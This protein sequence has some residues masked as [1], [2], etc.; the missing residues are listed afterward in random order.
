MNFFKKIKLKRELKSLKIQLDQFSYYIWEADKVGD[1]VE[2]AKIIKERD[3]VER[4]YI[5]IDNILNKKPVLIQIKIHVLRSIRNYNNEYIYEFRMKSYG[6]RL[7]IVNL[8][9]GMTEKYF[10]KE[11]DMIDWLNKNGWVIIK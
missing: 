6:Y 5:N 3:Q 4:E 10:P 9:A 1:F 8:K 7:K 2:M 11:S